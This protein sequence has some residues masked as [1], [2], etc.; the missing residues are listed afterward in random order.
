[1]LKK[2]VDSVSVITAHAPGWPIGAMVVDI[3]ADDR[4][5][6]ASI[7]PMSRARE[8]ATCLAQVSKREY[9]VE[10]KRQV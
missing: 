4:I 9:G 10:S 6:A 5:R 8:L 7:P 3:R 1:M 2:P